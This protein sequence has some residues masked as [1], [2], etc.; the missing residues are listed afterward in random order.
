MFEINQLLLPAT[1]SGRSEISKTNINR[2]REGYNYSNNENKQNNDIPHA[3][4]RPLFG[5]FGCI[6]GSRIAKVN[7]RSLWL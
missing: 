4:V 1:K 7:L 5:I 2:R 3:F 6:A